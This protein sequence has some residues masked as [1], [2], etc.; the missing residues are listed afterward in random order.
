MGDKSS[1]PIPSAPLFVARK[2]C[3]IVYNV[4]LERYWR[5]QLWMLPEVPATKLR[6]LS[7]PIQKLDNDE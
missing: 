5:H 2:N 3:V 6:S 7:D 1:R 4:L